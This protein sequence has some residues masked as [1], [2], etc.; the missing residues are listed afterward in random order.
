MATGFAGSMRFRRL[1]LEVRYAEGRLGGDRDLVEGSVA[2][3]AAVLPW[4]S[5]QAG[6]EARR[7][8][9]PLVVERWVTWQLGGRGDFALVG[10]S[11]RGHALLWRSLGLEVNVPPGSGSARGGEVGVTIDLG[12]RPF[13]FGL[14][15]EMDEAEVRGAARRENVKTLTLT[16][17]LRRR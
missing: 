11:V 6:P 1:E 17:G 12:P 14:A 7:Y 3:R 13:W 2:L 5:V 15:Y 10:S 9:T 4:L 16:A 8:D